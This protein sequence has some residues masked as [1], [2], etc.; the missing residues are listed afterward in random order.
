MTFIVISGGVAVN[1][2]IR[3]MLEGRGEHDFYC[4]LGTAK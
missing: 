3:C 4:A 2:F 1:P